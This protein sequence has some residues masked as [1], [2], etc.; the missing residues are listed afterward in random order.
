MHEK[1]TGGSTF[2]VYLHNLSRCK[3][4][5]FLR[6]LSAQRKKDAKKLKKLK[7]LKKATGAFAPAAF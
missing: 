3:N 5:H 6:N 2:E 7:K 1:R 4:T